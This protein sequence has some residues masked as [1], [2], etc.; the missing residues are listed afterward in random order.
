MPLKSI[1]LYNTIRIG[2][3]YLCFPGLPCPRWS[4]GN[5]KLSPASRAVVSGEWSSLDWGCPSWGYLD[6][7][8]HVTKL[9]STKE[10]VFTVWKRIYTHSSH[11]ESLPPRFTNPFP[12]AWWFFHFLISDV[13]KIKDL[14]LICE[15]AVKKEEIKVVSSSSNKF[16]VQL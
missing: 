13:R 10:K 6:Q 12:G 1:F 5:F 16:S 14:Y 9:Q 7:T 15:M 4:F 2:T 11:K 3:I 8:W